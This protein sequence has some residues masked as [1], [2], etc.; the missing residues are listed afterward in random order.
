MADGSVHINSITD[1][2]P[3]IQGCE[4]CHIV[5]ALLLAELSKR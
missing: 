5:R 3:R 1:V 2:R 4:E